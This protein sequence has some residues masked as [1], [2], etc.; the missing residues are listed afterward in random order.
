MKNKRSIKLA[1]SLFTISALIGTTIYQCFNLN[2]FANAISAPSGI[3]FKTIDVGSSD[4]ITSD[5]DI[6]GNQIYV[7]LGDGAMYYQRFNA[8]GEPLSSENTIYNI[9]DAHDPDVTFTDTGFAVVWQSYNVFSG[10]QEIRLSTFSHTDTP[11]IS[12]HVVS[13]DSIGYNA[14]PKIA[15]NSYSNEIGVTW[16][17]CEDVSCQNHDIVFRV[18]DMAGNEYNPTDIT[19]NTRTQD[20]QTYP[21]IS[22]SSGVYMITWQDYDSNT[23]LSSINARGFFEQGSKNSDTLIVSNNQNQFAYKP[24]IDSTYTQDYLGISEDGVS[25]DDLL[26]EFF[27]AWTETAPTG[28]DIYVRKIN[29]IINN[30]SDI[31]NP[32]DYIDVLECTS[33]QRGIEANIARANTTTG[34]N[35]M[36]AI[37][38][39]KPYNPIQRNRPYQDTAL[40]MVNVS[41]AF[42][43]GV[44]YNLF[45][46][47]FT[48]NLER[49]G[50]ETTISTNLNINSPI[51]SSSNQD[52]FFTVSYSEGSL[53]KAAYIP[54]QYLRKG[55]QRGVNAPDTKIQD[56]SKVSVANNGNYAI[57]YEQNNGNDQDIF[58]ALYDSNGNPIK[59]NQIATSTTTGDQTNPQ[60]G[61]F[62]EASNS[63]NL[64]KFIVSWEG[65]GNGDSSGIFYQ[66]FDSNGE[67]IGSENLANNNTSEIQ[68]NHIL[69]VGKYNQF[70]I[71]YAEGAIAPS[72]VKLFY[73][74][75]FNQIISTVATDL[76]T[77]NLNFALSPEADGSLGSTGK[78]KMAITYDKNGTGEGFLGAYLEDANTINLGSTGTINGTI[79]DI[80]GGYKEA[81]NSLSSPADPFFIVINSIDQNLDVTNNVYAFTTNGINILLASS[82][83][84][85]N[86]KIA[87]DNYTG[88]F[89]AYYSD[90][91]NNLY[92]ARR[93]LNQAIL[94]TAGS[95]TNL[96]RGQHIYKNDYTTNATINTVSENGATLTPSSGN[97]N[98]GDIIGEL[99]TY[100]GLNQVTSLKLNFLNDISLN[101]TIDQIVTGQTSGAEGKVVGISN[102]FIILEEINGT[103]IN[104]EN[105][106]N[107]ENDIIDSQLETLNIYF[108]GFEGYYFNPGDTAINS[109]QS[110]FSEV[111]YSRGDYITIEG[112]TFFTDPETGKDVSKF[113][114]LGTVQSDVIG[115]IQAQI[116]TISIETNGTLSIKPFG[117]NFST[118]QY[119]IY[120]Q[121]LI[122]PSIDYNSTSTLEE[123]K[124][125]VSTFSTNNLINELQLDGNGIYQQIFIDPFTLGDKEDLNPLTAQEITAGGKYIVVPQNINFGTISRSAT[126]VVNFADLN[127]A[128]LQVTDLDGTDFDLTASLTD[129]VNMSS[130][131]DIIPNSNF[132]IENND[133][134]NPVIQTTYGFTSANDVTIDPSTDPG[135]EANL[136]SSKTLLRKTNTNTG[137]WTICPTVKL[138]VQSDATSGIYLGTLT[139][140]LI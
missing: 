34:Y 65:E 3:P 10:N 2:S 58:V 57:V 5:T 107:I 55:D 115:T 121:S 80:D 46:Q 133:G 92:E 51:H 139:F 127:P 21:D 118:N 18:L 32:G 35:S 42:Q 111:Q 26:N 90:P 117:P 112:T 116:N 56:H 82:A 128:C 36:A 140:T 60:I 78:T 50:G 43:N 71:L 84:Q 83:G 39:Y 1:I 27:I 76:E 37:S 96:F 132:V 103:F 109:D 22:L 94:L 41:W 47:N 122:N 67:K 85:L 33:E 62:N 101:F 124:I 89:I 77:T 106:D 9:G 104:G 19:V 30:I 138:T 13:E 59:N 40:D 69:K 126:G 98:N 79:S 15:G 4:S 63:E 11:I 129:L 74:N 6:Y 91:G 119:K 54:S 95:N 100:P 120:G 68:S 14:K 16:E 48:N 72:N 75:N 97:F 137:S 70:G 53:G 105:L 123:Q 136:S 25:P 93:N 7:W 99:N 8:A 110:V 102:Y 125:F 131:T 134:T 87:I 28:S 20:D 31:E 88:N 44:S 86:S 17:K 49:S 66:Y 135:Q 61:F 12:G 81:L 64:G 24:S 23:D 113:N 130:P 114:E 45:S 108:D 52:G 29:C 73:N 38:A